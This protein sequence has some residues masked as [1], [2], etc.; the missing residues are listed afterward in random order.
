MANKEVTWLSGQVGK[1]IYDDKKGFMIF[2]LKTGKRSIVVKGEFL[3]IPKSSD[4]R[5]LG[6]YVTD[7]KYGRQFAAISYQFLVPDNMNLWK[8]GLEVE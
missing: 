2:L 3:Q 5:I 7:P 6:S 1:I 8:N 4:I